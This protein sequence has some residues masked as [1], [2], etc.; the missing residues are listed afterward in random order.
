MDL[1]KPVQVLHRALEVNEVVDMAA[2]AVVDAQTLG[3]SAKGRL[4]GGGRN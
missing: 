3:A 1:S 4:G 2:V